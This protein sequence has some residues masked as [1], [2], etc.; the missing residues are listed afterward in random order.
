MVPGFVMGM[1]DAGSE[2]GDCPR[3]TRNVIAR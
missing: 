2:E 3:R 1:G